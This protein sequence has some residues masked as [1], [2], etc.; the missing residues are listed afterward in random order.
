MSKSERASELWE[1]RKEE[2]LNLYIHENMS[3]EKIGKIYGCWGS[4]VICWLD[5]WGVKRR[6]IRHNAIYNLNYKIFDNIDSEHKAYWLGF[7]FADGHISNQDTIMLTVQ[8]KDV[9]IIHKWK[10]FLSA[11]HPISNDTHNNPSLNI[12]CKYLCDRFRQLG[13][14]NRKSYSIDFNKIINNIPD[15]LRNHFIRGM[16]DGDGCIK[17]YN[18]SYLKKPQYHF[19]YTGLEYVCEFIKEYLSLDRKLVKE[20]DITYTCVTRDLNKILNIRDF[21][22]KDSSIWLSR[23]HDVFFSL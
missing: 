8:K 16:V 9:E 12:K 22:Y 7:M 21:L 20:T 2:V 5:K 17:V 23:K 6:K 15:N 10:E 14:T 19:G 4:T 11:E 3:A 13:Y 1:S 18:Y